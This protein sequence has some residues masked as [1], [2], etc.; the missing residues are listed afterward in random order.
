MQTV[1]A[2]QRHKKRKKNI[3]TFNDLRALNN[4]R[5]GQRGNEGPRLVTRRDPAADVPETLCGQVR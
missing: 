2:S 4:Q 5:A 3:C 1:T